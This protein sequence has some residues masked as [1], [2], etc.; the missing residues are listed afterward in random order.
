MCIPLECP[1]RQI[2]SGSFFSGA[3][4]GSSKWHTVSTPGSLANRKRISVHPCS[5]CFVHSIRKF[6]SSARSMGSPKSAVRRSRARSCQ[7]PESSSGRLRIVK[8]LCS[9]NAICLTRGS[10]DMRV[11]PHHDLLLFPFY[12]ITF[13]R[14]GI[15]LTMKN[16]SP[17]SKIILEQKSMFRE[18]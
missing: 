17:C 12:S 11:P 2:T 5:P 4:S 7:S 16:N 6:S 3:F 9:I 8:R 14:G 15:D 10:K 1:C 18:Q 13:F